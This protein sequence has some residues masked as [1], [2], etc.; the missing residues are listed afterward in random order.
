MMRPVRLARVVQV[1][2]AL[3]FSSTSSALDPYPSCEDNFACEPG[4]SDLCRN[5]A[6]ASA[7]S[8]NC[9]GTE[10]W[11]CG[12]FNP[13]SQRN[14]PSCTF[15]WYRTGELWGPEQFSIIDADREKTFC[16][17]ICPD[18]Y[19]TWSPNLADGELPLLSA[20][21]LQDIIISEQGGGRRNLD[22]LLRDYLEDADVEVVREG[23]ALRQVPAVPA[24]REP[25][26]DKLGHPGR[27]R[28]NLTA[29]QGPTETDDVMTRALRLVHSLRATAE[30]SRAQARRALTNEGKC[31]LDS[32]NQC[33]QD[34]LAM[35]TSEKLTDCQTLWDLYYCIDNL[36]CGAE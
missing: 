17:N 4:C 33:G 13:E 7:S 5:R 20:L 15:A 26:D 8:P 35:S 25:Q 34:Y 30:A 10:N 23:P 3:G 36:K 18:K 31:N 24:V 14:L 19:F 6:T 12:P 11:M 29:A 32:V 9:W 2:L 16:T 22:N 1:V 21:E 27:L 28:H